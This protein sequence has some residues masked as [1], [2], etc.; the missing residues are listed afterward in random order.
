MAGAQ[1]GTALQHVQHLFS[2]GSSTGLS[3]T[4]LL[5]RFAMRGDEMAFAAIL[6]R[7]GPMVM[8]VCRGILRD[9][10]DADDAF[11]ATF[12]VLA[13]KAGAAWAEGQLGGWLHKVA[14]RIAIRASADARRRR[15]LNEAPPNG[16]LS[17]TPDPRSTTI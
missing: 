4:Q 12:L 1:L 5:G 13:R 7:H 3:D 8:T 9:A 15:L 16:R 11:Q 10:G 17:C 14:Y 2:D 6:S